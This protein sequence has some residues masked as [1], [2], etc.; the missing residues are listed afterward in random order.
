MPIVFGPPPSGVIAVLLWLALVYGLLQLVRGTNRGL[1]R[2][3]RF[4]AI[5]CTRCRYF[6]GETVL[7]CPVNPKAA[8]TEQA[9]G[10]TD[11]VGEVD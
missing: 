1:R 3:R 10:C 9:I 7:K 4:H 2:V 8:L 5:P 11:F 6:T